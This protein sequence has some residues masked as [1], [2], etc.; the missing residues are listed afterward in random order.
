MSDRKHKNIIVPAFTLPPR[1]QA[2][3]VPSTLGELIDAVTNS[4]EPKSDADPSLG[5]GDCRDLHE[6]SVAE[7]NRLVRQPEHGI[8]TAQ[9]RNPGD[10]EGVAVKGNSGDPVVLYALAALAAYTLRRQF[11]ALLKKQGESDERISHNIKSIEKLCLWLDLKYQEG[12][13]KHG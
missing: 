10:P 2:P 9:F 4:V 13:K 8:L 5:C 6:R 12:E 3:K 7:L 11:I 1:Q